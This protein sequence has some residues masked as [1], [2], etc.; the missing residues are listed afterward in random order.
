MIRSVEFLLK[1][2]IMFAV[3]SSSLDVIVCD[4]IEILEQGDKRLVGVNLPLI[5]DS[6]AIVEET[7]V[8]KPKIAMVKIANSTLF[9]PDSGRDVNNYEIEFYDEP[10]VLQSQIRVR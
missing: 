10:V 8:R 3:F 6:M 2:F 1:G 9:G 5:K 4:A 7:N